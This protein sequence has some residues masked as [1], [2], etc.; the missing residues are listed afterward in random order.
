MDIRDEKQEVF[1]EENSSK[2][3]ENRDTGTYVS[4]K[5]SYN[6]PVMGF[7]EKLENFWYHYK[8]HSIA[9]VVIIFIVSVIVTQSATSVKYDIDMIYAGGYSFSRLNVDGEAPYATALKSLSRI[10]ED[11][12]GDGE[13]RVHLNDH[14]VLTAEEITE[15]KAAGYTDLNEAR[16]QSSFSDLN[17]NI[18][19]D[20]Y[21][22]I[23]IS[24]ALY[25]YYCERYSSGLFLP[26]SSYIPEDVSAQFV[27]GTDNA[28]YLNSIPFGDMPELCNLPE[29]TVICLR[30]KMVNLTLGGGSKD[31]DLKKGESAIRKMFSYK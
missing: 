5:E 22:V 10:T 29:D 4:K 18:I 13:I 3:G 11:H 9:A 20:G 6:K 1:S 7:K 15:L 25:N 16:I 8:W 21:H 30:G 19:A 26:L 2:V 23:L 27:E 14:Y 28:V 17:T 31:E 24:E 12:N